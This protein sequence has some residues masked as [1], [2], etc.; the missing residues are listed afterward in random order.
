M[1]ELS[2]EDRDF[3]RMMIG[4]VIGG[5]IACIWQLIEWGVF[6]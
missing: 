4:F 5:L 2:E 3:Y 6:K 1:D